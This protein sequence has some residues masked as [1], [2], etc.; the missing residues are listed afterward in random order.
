ML[1]YDRGN[2]REDPDAKESE[3]R[4]RLWGWL[5]DYLFSF[6]EA[7]GETFGSTLGAHITLRASRKDEWRGTNLAKYP[8]LLT[9]R[10]STFLIQ[11]VATDD[12]SMMM[13]L[14]EYGP[15]LSTP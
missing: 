8:Y 15:L 14:R 2:L 13:F 11:C 10:T 3:M 7:E 12:I 6:Y 5:P 1:V 9:L 4:E